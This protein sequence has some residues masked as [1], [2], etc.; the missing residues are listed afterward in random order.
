ME[1]EPIRAQER[2]PA[3]SVTPLRDGV[4]IVDFGKNLAGV[5]RLKLPDRLLPGQEIVL[6]HMEFLDEEGDL[7]LPTLRGA[8]CRDTYIAAGDGQDP[9]FWQPRFTYHGFRYARVTGLPLVDKADIQAAVSYTHLVK[10]L[11][12]ASA[13][14][15][16]IVSG[17]AGYLSWSYAG[18][19]DDWIYYQVTSLKASRPLINGRIRPD[20]TG[21]EILCILSLIHI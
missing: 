20:G 9:A 17:G 14:P 18:I 10:P 1:L 6:E 5:C 4:S 3:R 8:R 7:Y 21:N 15:D 11:V 12:T 16:G 2:V 19:F 13:I